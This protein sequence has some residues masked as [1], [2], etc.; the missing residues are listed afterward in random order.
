MKHQPVKQGHTTIPG[1][2]SPTLS[3]LASIMCEL[4]IRHSVL[5]RLI[6]GVANGP[7]K[8]Q[9]PCK[10]CVNSFHWCYGLI[11]QAVM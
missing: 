5:V 8:K 11:F 10:I 1:I 6:K 7:S 9:D 2:S 4:F 3:K